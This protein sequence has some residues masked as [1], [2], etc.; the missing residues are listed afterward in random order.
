MRKGFPTKAPLV[1]SS[2][3]PDANPAGPSLSIIPAQT[4]HRIGRRT[5]APST[6]PRQTIKVAAA[7]SVT[8]SIG[9][10]WASDAVPCVAEGA[11]EE[12]TLETR[13]ECS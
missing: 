13:L 2:L 9:S 4:R 6:R 8:M 3:F 10:D 5:G 11:V 1:L 7:A 12:I